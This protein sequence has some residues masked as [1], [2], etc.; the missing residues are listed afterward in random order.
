MAR[1]EKPQTSSPLAM[2]LLAQSME[3]Q[4]KSEPDINLSRQKMAQAA[5]LNAQA[6][7]TAAQRK[8]KAK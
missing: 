4:A 2:Q 8:R 1:D 3:H 5:V 7:V 6:Q